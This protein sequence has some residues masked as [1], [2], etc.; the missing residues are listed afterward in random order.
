MR[1]ADTFAGSFDALLHFGGAMPRHFADDAAGA[2]R[3]NVDGAALAVEACR[4]NGAYLIYASTSGVYERRGAGSVAETAPLAPGSTYA[5]SKR[6][7][8]QA[9]LSLGKGVAV[10]R[11]FTVYGPQ[12]RDDMLVGYLVAQ[13]RARR[14]IVVRTPSSGRD[15]VH[16]DD[17]AAACIAVLQRRPS[18]TILNIGSGECTEVRSVVQAVLERVGHDV[19]VEWCKDTPGDRIW[20]DTALARRLLGWSAAIPL[21]KGLDN[22]VAEAR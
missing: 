4:R 1:V 6:L 15:F 21:A 11:L 2:W 8:E 5:E 14:P 13:A 7:A 17:V 10:L 3:A 20:A 9:C 12:Q 18:T 22:V 19:P 16:A